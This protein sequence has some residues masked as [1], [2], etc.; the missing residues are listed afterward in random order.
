M[1]DQINPWKLGGYAMY[2]VPNPV[3][4]IRVYESV[5]GPAIK[6]S[7]VQ[8]WVAT[9]STN[10]LRTFRCASVPPAA[11]VALFNENRALIGKSLVFAFTERRFYR[12]PP[13]TNLEPIGVIFVTWQDEGSFFYTSNFCGQEDHQVGT[14][15]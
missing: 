10:L 2:T 4:S 1:N 13:S 12:N 5:P 6:A 3:P 15:S 7:F 8:F 11:L 9:R 14:L